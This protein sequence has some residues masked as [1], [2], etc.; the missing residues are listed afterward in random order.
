MIY[1]LGYL[2]N[3]PLKVRVVRSTIGV[4]LG[5]SGEASWKMISSCGLAP[6]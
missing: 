2:D 4:L 3:V 1:L 6:Q 5:V